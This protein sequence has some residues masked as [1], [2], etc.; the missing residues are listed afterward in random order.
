MGDIWPYGRRTG[1]HAFD[2]RKR[3]TMFLTFSLV[4]FIPIEASDIFAIHAEKWH[5]YVHLSMLIASSF[6]VPV[7]RVAGSRQKRGLADRHLINDDA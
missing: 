4:A 3:D 1:E 6:A 2:F 5:L 7:L